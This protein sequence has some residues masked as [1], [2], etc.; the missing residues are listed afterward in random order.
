MNNYYFPYPVLI[1]HVLYSTPYWKLA[2]VHTFRGP[3]RNEYLAA[4]CKCCCRHGN[5]MMLQCSHL[6]CWANSKQRAQVDHDKVRSRACFPYKSQ[7]CS[8]E[9]TL[10][11][12]ICLKVFQLNF[13]LLYFLSWNINLN[14]TCRF[15]YH[16]SP[17][18]HICEAT[19]YPLR[20]IKKGK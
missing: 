15:P 11:Q 2:C 16:Y 20:K 7:K 18:Q 3:L 4:S 19:F 13:S 17:R 6:N 8:R 5:L 10:Q 14:V 1:L 12:R 9:K